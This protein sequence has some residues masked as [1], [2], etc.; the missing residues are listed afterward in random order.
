MICQTQVLMFF[1]FCD[2]FIIGVN[3]GALTL[4]GMGAYIPPII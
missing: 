4:G 1:R 2:A 3:R